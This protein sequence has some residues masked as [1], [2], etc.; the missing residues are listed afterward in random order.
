MLEVRTSGAELGSTSELCLALRGI[1]GSAS[2]EAFQQ[3]FQ[4]PAEIVADAQQLSLQLSQ[5]ETCAEQVD[6]EISATTQRMVMFTNMNAGLKNYLSH[7]KTDSD[8]PASFHYQWNMAIALT[9]VEN[10]RK[11]HKAFSDTERERDSLI[12]QAK[13]LAAQVR[14]SQNE[15]KLQQLQILNDRISSLG[16]SMQSVKA[17]ADSSSRILENAKTCM[18]LIMMK[19]CSVLGWKTCS[20]WGHEKEQ[21]FREIEQEMLELHPIAK[22]HEF[23]Q[24]RLQQLTASQE[25]L[26]FLKRDLFEVRCL[27]VSL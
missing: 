23:V 15:K 7:H 5:T 14:C 20:S 25:E 24:H 18:N 26:L 8:F 11:W 27:W 9:E 2:A 12:A 13:E 10:S 22:C 4:Q 21:R 3:A 1:N 19:G 6:S 17:N 16:D